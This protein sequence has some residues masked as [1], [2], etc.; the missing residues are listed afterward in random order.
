MKRILAVAILIIGA[1]TFASAQCSDAERQ[2][3]VAWDQSVGDAGVR[4]DRTFLATAYAEDYRGLSPS[5]VMLTKA[6]VLD[7]A[8][9]Q[10]EEDKAN[11]QGAGR[12]K[13]DH[14]DI[15]CTPN[16]A[17]IS[18]RT[19]AT[20]RRP[21]GA[22]QTNYSRSVHVLEK[23][24]GNWVMISNAG[25]PLNDAANLLYMERDLIDGSLHNDTK[26]FE[27][28][29]M[30]DYVSVN[31]QGMVVT[32]AQG[33][34]NAKNFKFDA[35]DTDDV[36]VSVHGDTAVVTGRANVKGKMGAQD[37]NGQYRYMRVYTKD[38]GHWRAVASQITPIV[39]TPARP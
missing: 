1:F 26:M 14:Y 29:A 27:R 30:D 38:N 15:T 39:Q 9:R 7:N 31:P 22:E 18:H 17:V 12:A 20:F 19:A 34:A 25:H 6:Q 35:I 11:P 5:G 8:M 3:L 13:Y 32:K 4:G 2:K 24:G 16:T 33:L 23:R 37:I 21:D 36:Q 10:Y 28:V